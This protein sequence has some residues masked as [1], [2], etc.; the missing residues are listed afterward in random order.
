MYLSK[1][2]NLIKE[3]INYENSVRNNHYYGWIT[4]TI[5]LIKKITMVLSKNTLKILRHFMIFLRYNI[6]SSFSF[7]KSH[8]Q[9]GFTK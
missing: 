7:Y 1:R 5:T 4:T 3:Y 9:M 6:V 8:G 2:F